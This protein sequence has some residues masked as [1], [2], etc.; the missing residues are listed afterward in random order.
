MADFAEKL[1]LGDVEQQIQVPDFGIWEYSDLRLQIL[2]DRIQLGF[3]QGASHD[4][5]RSA[6]EEFI[7]IVRSDFKTNTFGFNANLRLDLEPDEPDPTAQILQSSELVERLGGSE[8]RGGVWL[9]YQ[10]EDSSR[11]WIELVPQIGK[12]RGWVFSINRHYAAFPTDKESENAILA[13][14]ED[15]EVSLGEQCDILMGVTDDS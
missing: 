5:A 4:L 15:A 12:D 1:D 3:R 11:W 6:V 13:W 9:V 2:P 7:R 10:D 14:F 8:P